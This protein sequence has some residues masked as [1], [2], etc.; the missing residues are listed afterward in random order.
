[1]NSSMLSAL[2]RPVVSLAASPLLPAPLSACL[3][4]CL[5][6]FGSACLPV[7][8]YVN[9]AVSLPHCLSVSVCATLCLS[10]LVPLSLYS[11]VSVGVESVE[12]PVELF[13]GDFAS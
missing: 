12:S 4:C 6:A 1:M 7:C 5:A 9:L 13:L 8:P 3:P 2:Q 11:P 10:V